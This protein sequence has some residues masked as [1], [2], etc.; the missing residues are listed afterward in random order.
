LAAFPERA[1][2]AFGAVLGAF[3]AGVAFLRALAFFGATY[4]PRA[5][6]WAFFVAF[7]SSAV[8][9]VTVSIS[10]FDVMVLSPLAAIAAV[11]T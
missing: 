9:A 8:A 10:V 11:T 5:R 7:G 6:P 2:L 4:A 3:L 1:A